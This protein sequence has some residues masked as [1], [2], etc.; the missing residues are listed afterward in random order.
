MPAGE[1][2]AETLPEGTAW[3]AVG[4]VHH[5][6]LPPGLSHP[7]PL[8]PKTGRGSEPHTT[9]ELWAGRAGA[10]GSCEGLGKSHG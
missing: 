7:Q 9:E 1:E 8:H 3:G 5:G 6:C 10:V 4:E 2:S